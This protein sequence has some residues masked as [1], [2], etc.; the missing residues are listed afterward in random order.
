MTHIV[1]PDY[2]GIFA[3]IQEDYNRE[4]LRHS[5]RF[6]RVSE[7]RARFYQHLAFNNRCYR[8]S[9]IP[10]YS[11][12]RPL[13]RTRRGREL[14]EKF[15]RQSL[16]AQI[17]ACHQSIHKLK[18]RESELATNL[19]GILSR[20]V[21]ET[22]V[23]LREQAFRDVS[24][25]SKQRQKSKFDQLMASC[26]SKSCSTETEERLRV[27]LS[28]TKL[29]KSEVEVLKKGLNFAPAPLKVPAP[30][31]SSAVERGLSK[32]PSDV[33]LASIAREKVVDI[34]SHAKPP[35]SNLKPNTIQHPRYI[36]YYRFCQAATI[37]ADPQLS[38]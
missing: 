17:G 14:A 13:V 28:S 22:L 2:K 12:E 6:I 24:A 37:V 5:R 23:V 1:H 29:N 18:L 7:Q 36:I 38:G 31:I 35:A 11:G 20:E 26:S 9:I 27:N 8:Y 16:S 3:Y 33:D 10:K 30:Q 19:E 15:S 32:L 25:A 4:A 21:Y 34:L